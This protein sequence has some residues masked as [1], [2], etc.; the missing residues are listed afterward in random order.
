MTHEQT[1]SG[2]CVARPLRWGETTWCGKRIGC[3]P[4]GALVTDNLNERFMALLENAI[5]Q[6]DINLLTSLE[7]GEEKP[8][9]KKYTLYHYTEEDVIVINKTLDEDGNEDWT[10][11]WKVLWADDDSS[12]V[13]ERLF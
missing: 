3:V 6:I 2:E 12:I 5:E 8:L 11:V 7:E 13:F 4:S 9:N 10:E 1:C